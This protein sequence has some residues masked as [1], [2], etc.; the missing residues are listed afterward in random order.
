MQEP[1][2]VSSTIPIVPKVFNQKWL[3]LKNSVV[4]GLK[5]LFYRFR[6]WQIHVAK[7]ANSRG[8]VGK[9]TWQSWQIHVADSD[10]I[11]N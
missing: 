5:A 8:K 7:L 6:C 9:F 1:P 2:A 10:A 11:L 3:G 4:A